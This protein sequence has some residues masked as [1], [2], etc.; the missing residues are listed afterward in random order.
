MT[1]KH[2]PGPWTLAGKV[3]H[4][5]HP[6]MADWRQDVLGPPDASR[7][8]SCL[9]VATIMNRD[10]PRGEANA[11]LIA[12][13]PELIGLLSDAAKMLDHLTGQNLEAYAR[14]FAALAVKAVKK[15]GAA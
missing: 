13:A 7:G 14:A 3:N 6:K 2:T 9:V 5:T 1:T 8:D 12:A 10:C 11:R 4:E 15:A